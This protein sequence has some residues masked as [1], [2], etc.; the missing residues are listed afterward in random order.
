M[1]LKKK[2]IWT[3]LVLFFLLPQHVFSQEEEKSCTSAECHVSLIDQRY[4]HPPAE[5][6]CGSCHESNGNPHPQ[7]DGPEFELID[8]PAALCTAC[9]EEKNTKKVVH[10]PVEDGECVSCHNPHGSP[11]KYFLSYSTMDSVCAE[12]HD[13]EIADKA[14]QHGPVEAGECTT[15]HNPHQSDFSALLVEEKPALCFMC[16]SD[17]EERFQLSTIHAPA[18][19]DCQNC[20]EAHA[21]D[22]ERLLIEK[23]PA[24]CYTCHDDVQETV[25]NSPVQHGPATT[26]KTCLNCHFPHAS[27]ASSL[28]TAEPKALC[29]NCHNQKIKLNGFTL[30]NIAEK[31]KLAR[32]IHEPVDSDV[33]TACHQPHGSQ[34]GF[35][36]N[37]KFPRGNYAPGKEENYELCFECHDPAMIEEPNVTEDVTNF[38][39]GSKNLH[40]L[41]VG[42]KKGRTCINC[43]DV[44]ASELP[45]LIPMHV[46]FGKWNMPLNYKP[47]ENGGS[48]L[49]G[50]HQEYSYQR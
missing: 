40:Y 39:N 43:H 31:L 29:L 41:H 17:L 42:S 47:T 30:A 25:N 45:H 18:E 26:E 8:E 15:C 33:C 1:L 2:A 46:R 6:D 48:C 14:F 44:H 20:H 36:L 27:K 49:P 13:L 22:L 32:V 5:D 23:I 35:L 38:R 28:L 19:E 4:V 9:H 7:S 11:N 34:Y 24:L 3:L 10:P 12:C 21:S 37:A 16:H 50:C